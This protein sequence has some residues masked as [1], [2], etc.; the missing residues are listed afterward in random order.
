MASFTF[1]PGGSDSPA[2][3][4][5]AALPPSRVRISTVAPPGVPFAG[6]S[7][8]A[9]AG[10]RKLGSFET[11]TS[12]C[13]P[14]SEIF[15]ISLMASIGWSVARATA[16]SASTAHAVNAI[17]ERLSRTIVPPHCPRGRK[18]SGGIPAVGR[19]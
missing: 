17:F 16:A 13:L 15:M 11:K 18:G 2:G 7:R 1:H 4:L 5:N 6:S 19:R 12:F 10:K 3:T 8:L 14:E 9:I